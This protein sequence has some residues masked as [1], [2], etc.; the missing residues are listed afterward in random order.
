MRALMYLQG[1]L[2]VPITGR[3]IDP[4]DFQKEGLSYHDMGISE[5]ERVSLL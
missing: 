4:K 2:V 1:A 3:E 5:I